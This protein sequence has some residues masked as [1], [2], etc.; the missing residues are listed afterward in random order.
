MERGP[1]LK[2]LVAVLGTPSP[3]DDSEEKETFDA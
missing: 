3:Y 1:T 2:M